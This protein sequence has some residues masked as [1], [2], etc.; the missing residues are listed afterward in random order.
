MRTKIW[1]ALYT[2]KQ[3]LKREENFNARDAT[4]L[5][6]KI[7]GLPSQPPCWTGQQTR[8]FNDTVPVN[9][10]QVSFGTK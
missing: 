9:K 10:L 6:E 2:L 7:S 8:Q 4:H 5:P 3:T 1:D